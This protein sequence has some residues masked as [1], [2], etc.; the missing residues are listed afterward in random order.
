MNA[1]EGRVER[2]EAT[3]RVV[4]PMFL[5]GADQAKAELR[6]PSIKGALRFW[7]RALAWGRLGGDLRAIRDEED[8]LFGSTRTGQ[9]GVLMRLEVGDLDV[10]PK[11]DVLRDNG[12]VVGEGARYL[13]YGVMEAFASSKKGTQAGQLTRPCI[14]AP[15]SFTL[16][17]AF[18]P[19]LED[20]LKES[21]TDTLRCLGLV[22]GVGSK[23]RKG[24]GSLT[25]EALERNG[26]TIF[27][28]PKTINELASALQRLIIARREGEPPYTAFSKETRV[29]V[30][31]GQS[32]ES[33]LGLLDRIGRDQ[34]FFRS[35][36][37]GGTVL[38]EPSEKN[39]EDD[40]DLMKMVAAGRS[41]QS[42][43]RRIVFGL[44]HNYGKSKLEHV[45][46][47]N[48][49]RRASPLFIH[50]H[51]VEG[52]S[53]IGVLLFLPAQ[54][55]SEGERVK[56]GGHPVALEQE[57]LWNPVHEF[58]DRLLNPQDGKEQFQGALEVTRG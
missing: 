15:F 13:G 55:L 2:I 12:R 26:E 8:R 23:A 25:L 54:F 11:G 36:G 1:L 48:H 44:P 39:F 52:Q 51:H 34:V 27:S 56:V 32:S 18:K 46:P 9:A 45:E 29:V 42:H 31:P 35:W 19:K 49:D 5:S 28:S 6:L 7:W 53:P 57:T 58:M 21:M 37:Q 4:T 30:L 16:H 14:Q 17:L 33:A 24:Y 22:G 43:P 47:E 40:H 10:V 38:R 50:I 20:A 41:A 3:Y